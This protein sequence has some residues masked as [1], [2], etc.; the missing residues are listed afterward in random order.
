M[1]QENSQEVWL[2]SRGVCDNDDVCRNWMNWMLCYILRVTI[3]R[4]HAK[5]EN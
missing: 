3:V 5:N 1:R 4:S 2:M